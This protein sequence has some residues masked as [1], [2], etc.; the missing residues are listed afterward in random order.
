MPWPTNTRHFGK[1]TPRA[2]GPAK[3]AGRAKYT[4][5]VTLPGMLHAAILRSTWPAARIKSINLDKVR[6]APGIR[7]AVPAQEGEFAVRYYGAELAAIA[8]VSRHAVR[9]ALKLVEIKAEPMAFV[10]RELD[11]IKPDAV[12]VFAGRPNLGEG[13]ERTTG[14]VDAAFSAAAAVVETVVQ[15]QVEIHQPMEPHGHAVAWDGDDVT[16][17][18]STQGV[19]ACRNALAQALGLPQNKVRVICEH[20]GG[21]FGAKF[22][23]GAEGILCA[24][25]AKAAGAP[26]KLTL[27]RFEQALA[28]GNRPSSFQKIKLGADATGRLTAFQLESFGTSGFGTGAA[29]GGGSG[30]AAFPAPYLYTP[31][32]TRVKQG[33]VAVN[34]GQSAPMRAPG[35][36]VASVGIEAA[37][38][39]LAVKLGLDPLD[40]RILN[41]P[42]EVRRNEY[43]LGAEKIGWK[44]KY[45]KPGASPGPVKVGL[46]C[47]GAAW[48]NRSNVT[49]AEVQINSDAT[50]E[51]RVGTQDLGTGSRTVARV[52]AAEILGLDPKNITVSVGDTRLPT[53]GSSGGS[54]TTA[55]VAP[56]VYD[57]CEK[58]VAELA[59]ISG[60]AD[61][62]G[63]N[64]AG[65]CKKIGAGPLQVRG[66]WREGL[67]AGNAGGVQF[68]EV[69]VD[70]ETGF[71]KLRRILAVQD[72]GAV[73]NRL[74]CESQINGGVIM[75]IGYALYEER[76]MDR[77]TG[78][79]LNPN[80]ETYKLPGAADIPEI[81]VVLLDMP[82]R[83]V[84]GVG[85]PCTIPT[86]AAIA[87]AVANALGVRV[88]S[89][90]ITPDKVLAA[91]GK[92]PPA[93]RGATA[94]LEL[95]D[96]FRRVAQM[97]AGAGGE[98]PT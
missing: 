35:H 30:S 37:I 83:G 42:F 36:P 22:N 70:T 41:D 79:V 26:V 31:T 46:G 47:A 40:V 57:A 96:A 85:E 44:Q 94:Q 48:V 20:M 34:A 80:F 14:N 66:Q 38:D 82:E 10:V 81:D 87:N 64:W 61:P 2:E 7:A 6:A 78:V 49:H 77:A 95:N 25:L 58:A 62:R 91:L 18:S 3:A 52:V 76:V 59:K 54:Q 86:A 90:P 72:C 98:M 69:E 5:D 89:L 29:T 43:K 56:A 55:S 4:S 51:V 73:V 68:A 17:W 9:D 74:T 16:A 24:K 39:D 93:A 23:P 88:T 19:F 21:G 27:T 12:Q 75:G 33:T 63:A 71:V 60:V 45:R 67:S 1:A 15:T 53:S 92:V 65:A 13:K 32:A 50:V 97:P 11:A 84:I 28:V 8:G